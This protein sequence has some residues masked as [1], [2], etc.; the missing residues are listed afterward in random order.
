MEAILLRISTLILLGCFL[1]TTVK[2]GGPASMQMVAPI[3]L[4][5]G[6]EIS[7]SVVNMRRATLPTTTI[8]H[9][10]SVSGTLDFLGTTGDEEDRNSLKLLASL[11][12]LLNANEAK[13]IRFVQPFSGTQTVMVAAT[14]PPSAPRCL[15]PSRAAVFDPSGSFSA[16]TP[17]AEIAL[18]IPA[19][20]QAR[21]APPRE[22]CCPCAPVCGCGICP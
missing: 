8:Q 20:Q 10:G 17:V 16:V 6:A 22:A 7:F 19:V 9:C 14:V 12:F 1:T 11:P 3:T 13:P 21:E 2:A 4:P 15:S 18:L 5:E